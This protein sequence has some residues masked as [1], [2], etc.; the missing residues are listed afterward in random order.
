MTA[1]GDVYHEGKE[2]ELKMRVY[3]PGQLSDEL[4]RALGM[5]EYCPPPW[6]INM[7]RFGPPPS[8]PNLKIPGLNAPMP[9]YAAL[10]RDGKAKLNYG[11]PFNSMKNRLTG[12]DEDY[13]RKHWGDIEP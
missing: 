12:M 13:G 2:N 11:D 5:P 1:F 3:R 7:Q 6:L 8:Y 10:S 4:K 9:D